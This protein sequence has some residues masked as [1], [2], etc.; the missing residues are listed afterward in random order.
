MILR[1]NVSIGTVSYDKTLLVRINSLEPF[2]AIMEGFSEL[3]R[4]RVKVIRKSNVCVV[5][6]PNDAMN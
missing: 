3:M 5:T 4:R 1:G 6:K 2:M